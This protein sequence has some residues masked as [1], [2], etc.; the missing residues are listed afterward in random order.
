MKRVILSAIAALFIFTLSAQS[1][2]FCEIVERKAKGKSVKVTIDFGQKREKTQKQQSLVDK[3]GENIIFNSKID[4]LN[5]MHSLG[6]EFLQAYTVV[7]GSDGDSYSQI[8]WLLYKDV[9]DN[10]DPFEGITTKEMHDKSA[11]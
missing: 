1:R 9:T 3:N 10:Q 7:H 11:K 5:Y 4:A 8:H 2:V 6:W